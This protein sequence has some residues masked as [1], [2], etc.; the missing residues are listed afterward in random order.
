[1]LWQRWKSYTQRS[2]LVFRYKEFNPCPQLTPFVKCYWMLESN[3]EVLITDKILPDG[4]IEM[5]FHFG[6]QFV[7]NKNNAPE[8]VDRFFVNG[9]NTIP[10][11]LSPTGVSYLIGIRFFPYGAWPF[12]HVPMDELTNKFVSLEDLYGDN[13]NQLTEQL[14]NEPPGDRRIQLIEQFLLTEL[15]KSKWTVD[16]VVNKLVSWVYSDKSKLN[17]HRFAKEIKYSERQIRRKF[18][19]TIGINPSLFIRVVR[20]REV[21]RQLNNGDESELLGVALDSGYH[22]QSHFIRDFKNFTGQTP[23]EYFRETHIMARNFF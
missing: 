22:D 12:V 13:A 14:I 15:A 4:C 18:M 8:R 20:F 17:L 11:T 21:L 1:M 6:E 10:F 5:I 3:G 23:T 7:K 9:Q 16:P 2:T 19:D